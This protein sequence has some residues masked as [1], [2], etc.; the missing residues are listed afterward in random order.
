MGV[1]NRQSVSKNSSTATLTNNHH[2][3]PLPSPPRNASSNSQFASTSTSPVTHYACEHLLS[4]RSSHKLKNS[5]K[6]HSEVYQK[7]A[8]LEKQQKLYAQDIIVHVDN[9]SVK[10][11]DSESFDVVESFD[12]EKNF[13]VKVFDLTGK[14]EEVNSVLVLV[15]TKN[16][17]EKDSSPD[18]HVLQCAQRMHTASIIMKDINAALTDFNTMMVKTKKGKHKKSLDTISIVSSR[19]MVLEANKD[20]I[21]AYPPTPPPPPPND[22]H[23]EFQ[24]KTEETKYFTKTVNS[25]FDDI[26]SFVTKLYKVADA[27]KQLKVTEEQAGRGR[28]ASISSLLSLRAKPPAQEEYIDVF[29]KIKYALNTMSKL[30][31]RVLNPTPVEMFRHLQK[32]IV[33]IVQ[34]TG[35][36]DLASSVKYPMLK[37]ATLD[38]VYRVTDAKTP[39]PIINT[40]LWLELG[41]NWRKPFEDYPASDQMISE[42]WCPLF[43]SGWSPM[44]VEMA[45]NEHNTSKKRGKTVPEFTKVFEEEETVIRQNVGKKAKCVQS[46][47]TNVARELSVSQGEELDVLDDSGDWW[48]CRNNKG[49]VGFVPLT[50]LELENDDKIGIM[51]NDD[52]Q[53]SVSNRASSSVLRKTSVLLKPKNESSTVKTFEYASR[54][55]KNHELDIEADD[56][57]G[58]IQKHENGFWK[59]RDS[60]GTIGQVPSQVFMEINNNQNFQQNHTENQGFDTDSITSTITNSSSYKNSRPPPPARFS[61]K[62]KSTTPSYSTPSSSIPSAPS[63][64][65]PQAPPAPPLKPSK[66]QKTNSKLT[67]PRPAVATNLGPVLDKLPAIKSYKNSEI[68]ITEGM[69][70]EIFENSGSWWKVKS[71]N[72]GYCHVPKSIFPDVRLTKKKKKPVAPDAVSLKSQVS[73]ADAHKDI[74]SGNFR[75]KSV[76]LLDEEEEDGFEFPARESGQ[77]RLREDLEMD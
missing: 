59:V 12:F 38:M 26:E 40:S 35:G 42:K 2:Q 37:R 24:N 7:I 48:K 31:G 66:L 3:P 74:V 16:P 57:V 76:A 69:E 65:A 9:A 28:S 55:F 62:P 51:V 4:F 53:K 8:T 25:C 72:G 10:L 60:Y 68:V 29:K 54:A 77:Q 52:F 11:L 71:Y 6:T 44:A 75:L 49:V 14:F 43:S 21:E 47:I 20:L 34:T 61:S 19:S 22:Q 5:Q 41:E 70:L 23:L 1:S 46:W 18:I 30:E 64:I 36:V 39:K 58:I 45:R 56:R 27:Y 73:I 32:P 50:V 13:L 15:T 63:T 17:K 33:F 67:S